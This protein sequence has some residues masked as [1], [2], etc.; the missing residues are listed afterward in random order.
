[1]CNQCLNFLFTLILTVSIVKSVN[2]VKQE[3]NILHRRCFL[4]WEVD[5]LFVTKDI[6]VL[7]PVNGF[8]VYVTDW[9]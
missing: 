9:K 2:K 6:S 7:Q 8:I 5:A 3:V 1:M 4:L